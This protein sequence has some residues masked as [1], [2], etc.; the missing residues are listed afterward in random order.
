MSQSNNYYAYRFD[1]FLEEARNLVRKSKAAVYFHLIF[2][3]NDIW[4]DLGSLMEEYSADG[5]RKWKVSL[6]RTQQEDFYILEFKN[7]NDDNERHSF[8]WKVVPE[9]NRT[10]ILSFSLERFKFVR[11]CLDTFVAFACMEFPWL[12]SAFLE[13][14]DDFIHTTFGADARLDFKR[15]LYDL[16][17]IAGQGKAETNLNFVAANKEDILR[18]KQTEYKSQNRFFYIRR[19]SISVLWRGELFLFSISD[20]G[21]ILFEKGDLILFLEMTSA[22]RSITDFYR[23]SAEKHLN[24]RV[25]E[26]LV[27][28]GRKTEARTIESLD[29]LKLDITNPMTENWYENFTTLF[30]RPYKREEKLMSF[31]VMKGNPYFLAQIIDIEKGGSGVYLSATQDSIRISPSSAMT[32]VSTVLK[33]IKALQKYV[34][35]NITIAGA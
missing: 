4:E 11:S 2:C 23:S 30:S 9:G 20:E 31:V 8:F 32:N 22:L 21:E 24:I 29:V 1:N 3:R 25:K 14:I 15:I 19:V 26:T 10:V 27:E 33:I 17:P 34:D 12:G 18:R 28:E 16:E 7:Q 5:R 13:N 35:P 6:S